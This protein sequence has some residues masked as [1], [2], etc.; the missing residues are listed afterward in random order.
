MNN[1]T[2]VRSVARK[3]IPSETYTIVIEYESD[4]QGFTGY[5]AYHPELAGCRAQGATPAEA[6]NALAKAR[7]MMLTHLRAMKLPVPKPRPMR[8]LAH[9]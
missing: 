4:P 8:T 1:A 7:E 5:V 6:L 2:V 9:A 3:R